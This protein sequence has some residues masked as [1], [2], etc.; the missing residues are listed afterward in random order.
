M[1]DEIAFENGRISKFKGLVTLT[2]DR[3]ILH[4][5]VTSCITH[6]RLGYRHDKFHW[7]RRNFLWTD[8]PALLGRRVDL[9][10]TAAA[11]QWNGTSCRDNKTEFGAQTET[12]WY[13]DLQENWSIRNS[14]AYTESLTSVPSWDYINVL[15][16]PVRNW[17]LHESIWLQHNTGG[18]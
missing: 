8:G 16:M 17:T 1:V 9:E 15:N 12:L 14:D 6:R 10:R 5:V 13:T 7:N 18:K 2:L 3:V 4:T 11:W